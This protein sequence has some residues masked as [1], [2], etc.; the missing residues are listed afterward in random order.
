MLY[1]QLTPTNQ[2][3]QSHTRENVSPHIPI[4][5]PDQKIKKS[6]HWLNLTMVYQRHGKASTPFILGIANEEKCTNKVQDEMKGWRM[7]LA[8]NK[9]QKLR[10]IWARYGR[11]W[12]Q[13]REV[14][15]ATMTWRMKYKEEA[16]LNKKWYHHH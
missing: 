8:K 10:A 3:V 5:Y 1:H 11:A 15:Q 4:W 14:Q 2:P 16:L 9:V 13:L 7:L 12:F 6:I